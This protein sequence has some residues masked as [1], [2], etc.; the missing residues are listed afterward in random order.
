MI[1][2]PNIN[3]EESL[4]WI[5]ELNPDVIFCL[6]WSKLFRRPLLTLTPLGVVG[7]HPA[8]LPDNRGR[9]PLIWALI[10]RLNKTASTF[11]FMDEGVDSGDLISQVSID[12]YLSDDAASLYQRVTDVALMQLRDFFPSLASGAIQRIAQDHG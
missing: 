5:S 4:A 2:S 3:S 1:Y 9:H 7:F 6:G 12:I 11:F 8:A 10:L